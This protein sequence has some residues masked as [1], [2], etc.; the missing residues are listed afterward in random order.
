MPCHGPTSGFTSRAISQNG[1]KPKIFR[2]S[3]AV[4]IKKVPGPKW[5]T[6]ILQR[7]CSAYW[8]LSQIPL[9]YPLKRLGRVFEERDIGG[10]WQASTSSA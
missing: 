7:M 6:A 3:F 5:K 2:M 4:S 10:A 9:C 8:V 1:P